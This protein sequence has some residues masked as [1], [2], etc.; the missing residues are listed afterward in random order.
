M[1]FRSS[2]ISLGVYILF[3]EKEKTV[4]KIIQNIE[5]S[6]EEMIKSEKWA[7]QDFLCQIQ[8]QWQKTLKNRN[9]WS[10]DGIAAHCPI[11][12]LMS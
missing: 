12:F 3:G 4:I 9:K 11:K 7:F 5:N 6:E 8:I 2:S 10:K 1:Y